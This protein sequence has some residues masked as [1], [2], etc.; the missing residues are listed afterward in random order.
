MKMC[1]LT[2][3]IE[4]SAKSKVWV[5]NSETTWYVSKIE[6]INILWISKIK[7]L[8]S[9]KRATNNFLFVGESCGESFG[10]G[11]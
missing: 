6:Q 3:L 2:R 8:M 9:K 10:V 5:S 7:F 1:H 4:N 11:L